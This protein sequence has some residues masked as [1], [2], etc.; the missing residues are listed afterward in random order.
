M[1]LEGFEF[2]SILE[3][4]QIVGRDGFFNCNSGLLGAVNIVRSATDRQ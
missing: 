3:A 1:P 2:F 4:D